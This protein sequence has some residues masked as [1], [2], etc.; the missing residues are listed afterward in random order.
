MSGYFVMQ[1]MGQP[2]FRAN[3]GPFALRRPLFAY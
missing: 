2:D 1:R 3:V